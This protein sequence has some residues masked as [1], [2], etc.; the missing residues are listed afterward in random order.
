MNCIRSIA[1]MKDT[2][3]QKGL[4]CNNAVSLLPCSNCDK[5]QINLHLLNK[6]ET[7]PSFIPLSV[8]E[9]HLKLWTVKCAHIFNNGYI[10]NKYGLNDETFY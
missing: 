1:K 4:K 2:D 7:E 9:M 3:N 10:K 8:S 6:Q 5:A